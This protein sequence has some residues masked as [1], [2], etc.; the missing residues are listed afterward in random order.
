MRT[1][2]GCC[3]PQ[4]AV[5]QARPVP[6]VCAVLQ[7]DAWFVM[8]GLSHM[9]G[10]LGSSPGSPGGS[11]CN[12]PSNSLQRLS[13]WFPACGLGRSMMGGH[14]ELLGWTC[15]SPVHIPRFS[16]CCCLATLRQGNPHAR[17]QVVWVCVLCVSLC[18]CYRSVYSLAAFGGSGV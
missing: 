9:W 1:T 8:H 2:R 14:A 4:G 12:P 6:P 11:S 15:P 3:V 13:E 17:A 7:E 16:C 5:E 18:V 10:G